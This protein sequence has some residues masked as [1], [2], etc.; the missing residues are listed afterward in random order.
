MKKREM[1]PGFNFAPHFWKGGRVGPRHS[2]KFGDKVKSLPR[3]LQRGKHWLLR[4]ALA[5]YILKCKP[6]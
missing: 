3:F 4:E 5:N 2:F 1:G 6:M